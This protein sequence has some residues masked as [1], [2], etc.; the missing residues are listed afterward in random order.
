MKKKVQ[1]HALMMRINR[2]LRDSQKQLRRSRLGTRD[3]DVLGEYYIFGAR[4]IIKHHVNV[5]E[6][7]RKIGALKPGEEIDS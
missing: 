6:L 7:A 4:G 2:Q 3:R 1:L 5:E